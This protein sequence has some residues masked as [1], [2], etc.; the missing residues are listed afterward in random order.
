[1]KTSLN[2]LKVLEQKKNPSR[3]GDGSQWK[4]SYTISEVQKITP[5][6]G[7]S[8]GSDRE[9]SIRHTT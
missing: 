6:S 8:L 3:S 9:A 4:A 5:G 7:R 1:M 2:E